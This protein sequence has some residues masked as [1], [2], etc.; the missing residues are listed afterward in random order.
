VGV[1]GETQPTQVD[2]GLAKSCLRCGSVSFVGF[3]I[4]LLNAKEKQMQ[5]RSEGPPLT[6][7]QKFITP[8]I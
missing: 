4:F 8:P 3:D 6:T 1:T 5:K 2:I 7:S